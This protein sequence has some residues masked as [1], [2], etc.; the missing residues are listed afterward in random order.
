MYGEQLFFQMNRIPTLSQSFER[1][2]RMYNL[3]EDDTILREQT[4]KS[5]INKLFK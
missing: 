2:R 5:K 4:E 1:I 3:G